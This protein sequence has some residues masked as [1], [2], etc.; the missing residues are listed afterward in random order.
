MHRAFLIPLLIYIITEFFKITW[1]LK[2]LWR[3]VATPLNF[4]ISRSP[5]SGIA[6]NALQC[7]SM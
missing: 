5:V 2:C 7:N 1:D 4:Y 3:L 6:G